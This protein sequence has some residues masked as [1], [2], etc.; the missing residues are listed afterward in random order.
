[1][2]YEIFLFQIGD[3]FLFVN[4]FHLCESKGG[5]Y[6][7]VKLHF[8]TDHDLRGSYYGLYGSLCD[9]ENMENWSPL[10]KF[11]SRRFHIGSILNQ[12][13]FDLERSL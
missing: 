11:Q 5:L 12:E 10:Y 4:A 9:A 13:D 6:V 3:V 8:L 2:K 1:M 7:N